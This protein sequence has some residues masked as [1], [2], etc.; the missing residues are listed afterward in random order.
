[1]K[2]FVDTGNVKDIEALAAIGILDPIAARAGVSDREE[3]CGLADAVVG[4]LVGKGLV[5][6]SE[7]A[8]AKARSLHRPPAESTRRCPQRT[9]YTST[10]ATPAP[11]SGAAITAV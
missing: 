5:N 7:F 6:D 10:R 4:R 2:L 11:F 9:S 3:G 8:L 1:M